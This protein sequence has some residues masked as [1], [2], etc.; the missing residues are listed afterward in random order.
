V[1]RKQAGATA[2][3]FALVFIT[4]L[5]FTLAILDVARMLFTWNAANEAARA[6][7]RYAVVCDNTGN[8]AL[9]LAK[10]QTILPQV[11]D[12]NLTLAW[13]PPGC[14]P[15]SCTGVLVTITGLNY[16]FMSPIAGLAK[17]GI[18][19]MPNFPTYLTREDM[20]QD[21]NAGVICP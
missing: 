15:T 21:A 2:V 7:A 13:D 16:N 4:F 6:G 9:V 5:A 1:K 8:K 3:E 14:N 19:S 12:T 18:V 10:M 20:R 17:V 11:Q